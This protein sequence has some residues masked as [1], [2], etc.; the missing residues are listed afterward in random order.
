MCFLFSGLAITLVILTLTQTWDIYGLPYNNN[1]L[2][3]TSELNISTEVTLVSVEDAAGKSIE[4]VPQKHLTNAPINN[5]SFPLP[6]SSAS[7][8]VGEMENVSVGGGENPN[9]NPSVQTQERV[10]NMT[11][12]S[13]KTELLTT[14]IAEA[15]SSPTFRPDINTN[16]TS[17]QENIS[18]IHFKTNSSDMYSTANSTNPVFEKWLDDFDNRS[19]IISNANGSL[20]LDSSTNS[21]EIVGND[22]DLPEAIHA[23]TMD[24]YLDEYYRRTHRC[25]E[26]YAEDI[27]WGAVKSG[28]IALKNC[29]NGY[30]GKAYRMCYHSGRWGK[31]DR[32]DCQIELLEK[33]RK[34]VS[35]FSLT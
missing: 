19:K 4:S 32:L 1:S 17:E 30:F 25:M 21:S 7:D 13:E 28:Q 3:S 26:E 20:I 16:S 6:T 27:H 29:N 31:A 5:G 14:S 12:N 9:L 18:S 22:T 33:V 8:L 34:L 2:S 35:E 10:F 15:L 23:E 11:Q 24:H